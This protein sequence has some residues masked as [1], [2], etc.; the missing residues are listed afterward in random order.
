MKMIERFGMRA[1][2]FVGSTARRVVGAAEDMV[3]ERRSPQHRFT[4]VAVPLVAAGAAAVA[5]A[6]TR[7]AN[8]QGA[9]SA[10]QRA[11][12][13]G[14]ASRSGSTRTT[15]RGGSK[16]GAA[17]ASSKIKGAAEHVG[18]KAEDAAEKTREELYE[19]AKKADIPGR[20]SMSK[21]E[22]VKALDA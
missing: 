17:A 16:S 14:S 8:S 18:S 21:E 12:S 22:L 4:K 13:N 10:S 15:R 6:A 20:S 19:L 1:A 9:A 3:N 11:Q 2:E 5:A 7:Y